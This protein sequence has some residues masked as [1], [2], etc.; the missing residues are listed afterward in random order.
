MTYESDAAWTAL[1]DRSRRAIVMELAEGERTVG[2]L[3]DALP[4]SQPAV[5]QHLKVLKQI[6]LVSDRAEGTRRKYRLNEHGVAALRDQL[7]TFWRR[8]LENFEQHMEEEQ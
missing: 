6:G 2:E 5:S 1:A 8:T 7:D 4:I 3:T